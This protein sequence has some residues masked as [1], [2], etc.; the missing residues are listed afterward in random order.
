ME[1]AGQV[2]WS[3]LDAA[4]RRALV[5]RLRPREVALVA[6]TFVW[7][8]QPLDVL[9][10]IAARPDCTLGTALT[11]FIRGKPERFEDP[12]ADELTEA[13]RQVF[14]FLLR[15]HA[16][17]NAGAHRLDPL[18]APDEPRRIE[19]LLIPR[20]ERPAGRPVWGLDP[21]VVGPALELARRP[22][23]RLARRR[24]DDLA[25]GT[26]PVGLGARGRLRRVLQRLAGQRRPQ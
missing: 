7:R 15:L 2:D 25:S 20:R 12:G 1:E 17:I 13:D 4:A 14:Q 24:A 18:E 10:A 23:N 26:A 19:R 22:Q 9:G 3:R 16:T 6:R 21:A 8:Q 11:I 5:H